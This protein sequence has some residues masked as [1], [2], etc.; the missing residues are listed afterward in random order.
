MI[1]FENRA[2]AYG[3][4]PPIQNFVALPLRDTEPSCC[5]ME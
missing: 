3:V 2:S 5:P 4:T 1:G